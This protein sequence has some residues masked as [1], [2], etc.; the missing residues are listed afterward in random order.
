MS[1]FDEARESSDLLRPYLAIPFADHGNKGKQR[2]I[3][4]KEEAVVAYVQRFAD[5]VG[6]PNPGRSETKTETVEIKLSPE[7]KKKYVWQAYE[8]LADEGLHVLSII[9]IF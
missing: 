3:S 8:D 1:R 2:P 6:F 5:V 9:W 4:D 7:V